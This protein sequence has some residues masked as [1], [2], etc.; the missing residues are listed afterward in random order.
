MRT[1]A[2]L[3]LVLGLTLAACQDG[4]GPSPTP[5]TPT[6]STPTPPTPTPP[7]VGTLV[8]STTRGGNDPNQ[9]GYLLTVDGTESLPLGP[10]DT[11]RI[12]LPAGPHTLRLTGLAGNCS[13]SPATPL[14]VAI[15]SGSTTAVAFDVT[16]VVTGLQITASTTGLEIDR[17]GYRLEV[18]GTDR[19]SLAANGTMLIPLDPGSRTIGLTDLA[20]NCAVDGPGSQTVTIVASE[21]MPIRF[22]VVCTATTTQPT[23]GVLAFVTVD[24]NVALINA[25]GTHYRAVT[26]ANPGVSDVAVAW[27]PSGD[28]IAFS[29]MTDGSNFPLTI[30][31]IDRDGTNLVRLSPPGA[32]DGSPTW[33]P[34]GRRIAF[35]NQD[36]RDYSAARVQIYRMNADGTHRVRLTTFPEGAYSPA[37]SPDGRKIVFVTGNDDIQVMDADGTHRSALTNDSARDFNPAWS[38]DGNRI[39]FSSGPA[40]FV[41]NA[42][43]THRTRLT[44]PPETRWS[45]WDYEPAWSPDGHAVV[46]TRQY[47]CDPFNDNGG[48]SCVRPELRTIQPTGAPF[49]SDLVTHGWEASWRP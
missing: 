6:P 17:D 47:D 14:D 4:V 34:D 20:A 25:N 12:D 11:S 15:S 7:T 32:L 31:V 39:V 30:H 27:S 33:S 21:V 46:F 5:S 1:D 2:I 29:R 13:V 9:T 35:D 22:A 42:D 28:R 3:F 37:W 49:A 43:G 18:D 48:P 16:C 8:V 26:T 19:G 36:P 41:I 23:S 40:L 24:N 44:W 45:Y 38:P 10:T